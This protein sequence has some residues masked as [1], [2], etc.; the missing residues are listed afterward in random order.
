MNITAIATRWERGWELS[1]DGETVTQVST[2]DKAEQ[3]LL[4][5]LETVHEDVPRDQ[6]KVTVV[7]DLGTLTEHVATARRA[8]IEAARSQEAAATLSRQVARELREHGLSV[9]DS[10]AILGVSRG[11]VSQLVNS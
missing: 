2:L 8:T 4:D 9:S 6:W 7:P 1:I 11:R 5:Y 3:Q 10:A